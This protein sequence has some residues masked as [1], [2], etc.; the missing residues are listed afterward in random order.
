MSSYD[1][2][3][4]NET[5]DIE[6]PA[7]YGAIEMLRSDE[8]LAT[9]PLREPAPEG[10]QILLIHVIGQA[11]EDFG[12]ATWRH[13]VD[14]FFCGPAFGRYCVLLGWNEDWA[15]RRIQRFVAGRRQAGGN[16]RPGSAQYEV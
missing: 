8:Q 3:F 16:G 12:I 11:I 14:A 5:F 6:I 15:R 1:I 2:S 10:A 7:C 13:E 4:S 9:P